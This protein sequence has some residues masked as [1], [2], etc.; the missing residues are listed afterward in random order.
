M[1]KL[2][3]GDPL[4][5]FSAA[6]PT[7]TEFPI[8]TIGG[9]IGVFCVLGRR[10][11]DA[12]MRMLATLEARRDLFDGA[13][14]LLL[15][16]ATDCTRIAAAIAPRDPGFHCLHDP[17]GE[18][19]TRLRIEL[20]ATI[21]VD[22]RLR[23]IAIVPIEDPDAHAAEL[24]RLVAALPRPP[25]P[26]MAQ[27]TAPVLVV[28]RVLEPELCDSLISY[29]GANGG[30]ATGFMRE[31]AQG[32]TV[33]VDD[34][35]FKRRRDCVIADGDL[36]KAVRERVIRRLVPELLKA[37]HYEP[38][39]IERYIVACYDAE[40]AGRFR[41]HRDNTTKG[42]AHRRFAVTL[43]LNADGYEG[44]DLRFPEYDDRI[45]RAPTGGA[46]VFS[47]SVLH[48][49]MPVRRGRRYCVLPFLYDETS[50]ELRASNAAYLADP[51]LQSIAR[52]SV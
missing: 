39:R 47:C 3:V 32:R 8:H 24:A 12:M 28:P 4:P 11:D 22:R 10:I 36:R 20:P 2:L 5:W 14:A 34:Q 18:I 29:F 19:A 21:V 31:D 13:H 46:V 25:A 17:D 48:E 43:N 41:A 7:A 44:G 9:R 1:P 33:M 38:T 30:A 42:T 16:V 15:A 50:A 35:R 37:F 49:A 51:E 40:E 23:V 52:R 26:T 27:S 45:Y 6:T